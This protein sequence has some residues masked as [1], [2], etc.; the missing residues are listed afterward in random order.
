[1]PAVP[2]LDVQD[3]LVDEVRHCSPRSSWATASWRSRNTTCHSRDARRSS[4]GLSSDNA[5]GGPVFPGP[6]RRN[7]R[8]G[9]A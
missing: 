8:R 1:M 9:A 6:P 2:G 3:R 4:K 5:K 7:R